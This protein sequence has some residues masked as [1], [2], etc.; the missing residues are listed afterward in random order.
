MIEEKVKNIVYFKVKQIV[1]NVIEDEIIMLNDNIEEL[2][3][4]LVKDIVSI[5]LEIVFIL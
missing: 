3:L 5:D 4:I 1:L 2:P